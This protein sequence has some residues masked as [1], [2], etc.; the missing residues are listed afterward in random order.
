MQAPHIVRLMMGV[1]A[2]DAGMVKFISMRISPYLPSFSRTPARIMEPPTG[3][4]T[5][6]FGSHR[7]VI[8]SGILTRNAAIVIIHHSD[9]RQVLVWCACHEGR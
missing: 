2:G 4:S 6:A 8:Y 3:A 1:V 7:W 9:R 5:W